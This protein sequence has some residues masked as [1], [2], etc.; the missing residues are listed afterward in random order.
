MR[1]RSRLRLL[2]CIV[3]AAFLSW[4]GWWVYDFVSAP[5]AMT[6]LLAAIPAVLAMIALM[7]VGWYIGKFYHP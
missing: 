3:V 6:A 4:E 5:T 7:T 2:G 1:K